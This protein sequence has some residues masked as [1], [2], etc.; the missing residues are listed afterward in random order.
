MVGGTLVGNVAVDDVDAGDSHT[1]ELANDADGRFTI[2]PKTGQIR[3]AVGA[4]LDFEDASRHEITVR[5]TD[6]AGN[7]ILKVVQI[8]L[9]DVNEFLPEARVALN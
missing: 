1:Y 8:E 2:D 9:E 5:V 4:N 3:V 7:T 6:A